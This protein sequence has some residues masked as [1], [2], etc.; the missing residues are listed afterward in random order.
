ME[1]RTSDAGEPGTVTVMETL[2]DDMS[3][4]L[5]APALDALLTAGARDAYI[6]PV[7]AKKGRPAFLVTVLCD[8]EKKSAMARM[9]F[10]H[11][12]TLG[13][14]FRDEQR[15]TL[16]RTWRTVETEYGTVRVKMGLVGGVPSV[17]H[18]EFEDCRTRASEAGVPVR[19]VADAAQAA[20]AAGRW[21]NE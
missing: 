9:L 8:P 1:S 2:V 19:R 11:T 16:E 5:F 7:M 20:A 15:M 3:G 17:V 14:R 12:T 18:P 6:T 10:D 4:E 21:Q 13:V